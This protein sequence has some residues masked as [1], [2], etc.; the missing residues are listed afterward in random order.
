MNIKYLLLYN[1]KNTKYLLLNNIRNTRCLSSSIYRV[2]KIK[3]FISKND[4]ESKIDKQTFEYKYI[5]EHEGKNPL[6]I[7]RVWRDRLKYLSTLT[8]FGILFISFIYYKDINITSFEVSKYR[9]SGT[10][11]DTIRE[12][13]Q[14][15]NN[16]NNNNNNKSDKN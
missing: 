2:T 9:G 6:G 1:I 14:F 13:L 3:P 4:N 15:I 7:S 12:N 8:A 10:I 11:I 16:N 5:F